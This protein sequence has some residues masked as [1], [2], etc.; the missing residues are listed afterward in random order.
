MNA[1]TPLELPTPSRTLCQAAGQAIRDFD[2]IRDGDRVLVGLSGGKDSMSLLLTLRHLQRRAPVRFDLAAATVDP[3]MRGFDPAPLVP[4]LERLGIPYFVERYNMVRAA[5][6]GFS[7]RSLCSFCSRLRRG[8]LYRLARDH[9]YNSLAI[10]HHLDDA[11]ETF[12]MSSFYGGK[13]RTMRAAYLNDDGDIRVIRPL[14]YARERQTTAFAERAGLPLIQDNCPSCDAKPT[15]R[16][17]MKTLLADMEAEHHHLF[18]NLKNALKP[19]L[20]QDLV[21]RAGIEPRGGRRDDDDAQPLRFMSQPVTS[22]R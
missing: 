17:R 11:A 18:A 21:P 7:G 5:K 12:L 19:L 2:L 8:K 3:E 6:Q 10:G 13:L 16:N 4:Y 20:E 1:P 22:L 14:I 9:G 15:Q